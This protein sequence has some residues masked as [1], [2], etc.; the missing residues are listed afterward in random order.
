MLKM[1]R[2]LLGIILALVLAVAGLGYAVKLRAGQVAKLEAHSE[3]LGKAID[4][5]AERIRQDQKALV[6]REA[7][8]AAQARKLEKAQSQL[9]AAL[10][11][12][13]EWSEQAVPQ[14]VQGAINGTKE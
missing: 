1:N 12:N 5:A 2:I 9:A 10:E 7:E 4:R 3:A 8:N 6:A 11:A 13:Q 14:D